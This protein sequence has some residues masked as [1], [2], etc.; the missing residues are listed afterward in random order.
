MKGSTSRVGPPPDGEN[1]EVPDDRALIAVPA[2]WLWAFQEGGPPKC[3]PA[4]MTG[5][6]QVI[7]PSAEFSTNNQKPWK[8]L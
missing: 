7:H 1:P 3:V 6:I 5:E 4:S 8:W 2:A